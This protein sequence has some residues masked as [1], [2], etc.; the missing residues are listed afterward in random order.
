MRLDHHRAIKP[1]A[2]QIGRVEQCPGQIGTGQVG[3]FHVG[4]VEV[5]VLQNGV[6][7][8]AFVNRAACRTASVKIGASEIG[9]AQITAF[10]L[11]AAQVAARA[12]FARAGEKGLSFMRIY[13]VRR[14]FIGHHTAGDDN[15]TNA[16]HP[17]AAKRSCG[18]PNCDF[19]TS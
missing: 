4:L 12:V 9:A 18:R 17:T 16:P 13:D 6:A 2:T 11:D 10:Q 1:G 3:T 8:F 7:R 14:H 19:E 15:E 5:C